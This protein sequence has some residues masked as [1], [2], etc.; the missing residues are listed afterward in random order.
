MGCC[1][2]GCIGAVWPRLALILIWIFSRTIPQ[3]TFATYV[4]PIL[5][6]I[7]LPATTLVYELCHFYLHGID[8]PITLVLLAFLH[9]VGSVGAGARGRS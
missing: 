1:L 7:F 6:F 3:Q 5:G 2:I 4:W 8:N 9:D